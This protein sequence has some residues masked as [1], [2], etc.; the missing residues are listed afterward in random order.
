MSPRSM[1]WTPIRQA[2]QFMLGVPA[3]GPDHALAR[4]LELA[5][6]TPLCFVAVAGPGAGD[7]M[8]QLW[9]RGYQRV[10]AAR[11][12]T[13]GA[14]DERSDL[15]RVLGCQTVPD[16][17]AVIAATYAMLRPG[18]TLV[19]DAGALLDEPPRRALVESLLA[20]GLDVQPQAHLGAEI[21][22]TRPFSRKRAAA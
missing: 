2:A 19:V 1:G 3:D 12:A 16:M 11:R 22:A 15:L 13:C 17:R 14:A 7:A 5:Q 18:G 4:M 8:S 9:R 21:L 6:A 20:L 10:E